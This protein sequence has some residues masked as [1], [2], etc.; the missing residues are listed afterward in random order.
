MRFHQ[1]L[2]DFVTQLL[3]HSEVQE[4]EVFSALRRVMP[5]GELET[6][7]RVLQNA[8]EHQPEEKKVDEGSLLARVASSVQNE[9][10]EAVERLWWSFLRG[11]SPGVKNS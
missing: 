9:L 2:T 4:R 5:R 11:P 6:L 3:A 10:N 1:Q 7:G 8:R